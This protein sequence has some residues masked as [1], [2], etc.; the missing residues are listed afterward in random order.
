MIARCGR[1]FAA[2]ALVSFVV[3]GCAAVTTVV[4]KMRAKPLSDAPFHVTLND[5]TQCMHCHTQVA[6]APRVP[7]PQYKKCIACHQTAQ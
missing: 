6:A 2:A 3:A 1:R 5:K 4:D 7:H